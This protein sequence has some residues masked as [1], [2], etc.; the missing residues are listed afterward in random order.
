MK[1]QHRVI[2]SRSREKTNETLERGFFFAS[3]AMKMGRFI[4]LNTKK[5]WFPFFFT[6]DPGVVT[7][8]TFVVR[9]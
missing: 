3:S 1:E 6:S 2:S 5:N 7:Q 4:F 9:V 8:R